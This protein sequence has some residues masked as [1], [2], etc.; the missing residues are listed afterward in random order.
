MNISLI[1]DGLHENVL[2][3][4]YFVFHNFFKCILLCLMHNVLQL[5]SFN[6]VS[7]MYVF[8][9]KKIARL[10]A[11]IIYLRYNYNNFFLFFRLSSNNWLGRSKKCRYFKTNATINSWKL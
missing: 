3:L 10:R 2:C 7:C 9:R 4:L 1:F 8:R 6:I 11:N 5:R